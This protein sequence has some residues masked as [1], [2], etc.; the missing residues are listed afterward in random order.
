MY[1]LLPFIVRNNR[2]DGKFFGKRKRRKQKLT[3]IKFSYTVNS[4]SFGLIDLAGEKQY[5]SREES[6]GSKRSCPQFTSVLHRR[7]WKFLRI[8][9]KKVLQFL[10]FTFLQKVL[11]KSQFFYKLEIFYKIIAVTIGMKPFF[12][13]WTI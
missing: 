9:F 6:T 8:Y 11:W 10:I 2:A 13:Y 4:G 5:F 1:L 3:E 7:S 12:L